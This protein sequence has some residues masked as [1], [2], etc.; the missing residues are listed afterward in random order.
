MDLV[1]VAAP[2]AY[3]ATCPA[4]D[5]HHPVVRDLAARLWRDASPS[6]PLR[7]GRGRPH[8]AV[9]F[10]SAAFHHVR[11]RVCHSMDS[12]EQHVTWRA[13]DVLARSTGICYAKAHALAALLRSQGLPAA[14]AA[15]GC[16]GA[17][18]EPPRWAGSHQASSES[19]GRAG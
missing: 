12:G 17:G 11:D 5:H 16:W 2:A 3:L 10:A 15:Y 18:A 7:A 8:D 4:V 14:P 13:S 9:A 1:P 6:A 19:L